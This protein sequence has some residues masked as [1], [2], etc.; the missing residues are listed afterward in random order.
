MT[1]PLF[2]TWQVDIG[3]NFYFDSNNK[4]DYLPAKKA[5]S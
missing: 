2:N 3:H 1:D 4:A 5:P